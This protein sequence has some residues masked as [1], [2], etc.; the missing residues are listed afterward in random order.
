MSHVE[1]V[2]ISSSGSTTYIRV[3]K[4]GF[5]LDPIQIYLT[6]TAPK[7]GS[8]TITCYGSAWTAWWGSI[9]SKSVA[10]FVAQCDPTY[11]AGKLNS[12]IIRRSKENY[13]DRVAEAV[14]KV[15]SENL[16]KI[17]LAP[18]PAPT[19]NLDHI[20]DVGS[21]YGDP[22]GGY[23]FRLGEFGVE[24]LLGSHWRPVFDHGCV[25]FYAKQW[26]KRHRINIGREELEE[27][28][29]QELPGFV[30]T[31]IEGIFKAPPMWGGP[32]AV[33]CQLL[34]LMTIKHDLLGIP[35]SKVMEKYTLFLGKRV[36]NSVL[37]LSA[38]EGATSDSV[39]K[40]LQEFY[41]ELFPTSTSR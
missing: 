36:G 22:V 33:E 10:E 16:D 9:G 29:A 34:L 35:E 12:E 3:S 17:L 24:V 18:A 32:E 4:P 15:V 25:G 31:K 19:L 20:D 21:F 40:T 5:T 26:M 28:R 13:T 37:A 8:I 7:Q 6:D 41:L 11:L 2:E 23:H 39:A 1:E 38:H 14:I 27:K 30:D